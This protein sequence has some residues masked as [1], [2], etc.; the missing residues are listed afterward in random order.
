MCGRRS[1]P[2]SC[3]VQ[4]SKIK[5]S[6]TNPLASTIRIS[7]SYS[8]SELHCKNETR[9]DLAKPSSSIL[10]WSL[11]AIKAD[12]CGS[13]TEG[14]RLVERPSDVL[15]LRHLCHVHCF[16]QACTSAVPCPIQFRAQQHNLPKLR[17][18]PLISPCGLHFRS[19]RTTAFSTGDTRSVGHITTRV[20]RHP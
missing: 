4:G 20:L 7:C 9:I 6:Y 5:L 14:S 11:A 8:E 15:I 16:F 1:R 10:K 17:R 18:H 2:L 3:C 12:Y 19:P 13:M